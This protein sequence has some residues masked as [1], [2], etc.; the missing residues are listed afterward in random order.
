MSGFSLLRITSGQ[1][2]LSA[3]PRCGDA[4]SGRSLMYRFP[5]KSSVPGYDPC[6]MPLF[7]GRRWLDWPLAIFRMKPLHAS[8][9]NSKGTSKGSFVGSSVV[10]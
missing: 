7:K 1:I 3:Y 5:L 2:E 8:T 9:L 10:D 6:N 4:V